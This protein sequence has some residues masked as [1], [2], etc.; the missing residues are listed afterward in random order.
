MSLKRFKATTCNK[1]DTLLLSNKGLDH[2]LSPCPLSM[3]HQ[4]LGFYNKCLNIFRV[5]SGFVDV[6]LARVNDHAD[7]VTLAKNATVPVV[8]YVT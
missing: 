6:I 3:H 2:E 8:K 5:L 7:L 1:N 4:S